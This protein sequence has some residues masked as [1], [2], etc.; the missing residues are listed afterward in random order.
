MYFVYILYSKTIDKY[1][2]GQTADIKER[3]MRH[4]NSP[5]RFTARAND[6][7]IVYTEEYAT[8]SD[9]VKRESQLKR[10]K[11]RKFIETLIGHAGGRPD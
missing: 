1:Y 11:S 3:I 9:A 2:I 7:Q 4:Q 6:W 5:T 8:R 10:M